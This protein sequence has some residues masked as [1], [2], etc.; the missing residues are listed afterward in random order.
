MK[1]LPFKILILVGDV[2]KDPLSRVPMKHVV[3]ISPFLRNL[4]PGV[5]YFGAYADVH[6]A[7]AEISEAD[8]GGAS[9]NRL[10]IGSGSSGCT[11]IKGGVCPPPFDVVTVSPDLDI[12]PVGSR[13][14]FSIPK[15]LPTGCFG[16]PNTY[17]NFGDGT[18]S[19]GLDNQE[20]DAHAYEYP[21][22][23]RVMAVYQITTSPTEKY[24]CYTEDKYICIVDCMYGD[25][26]PATW[27]YPYIRVIKDA[28]ITGGCGNGNY[29][30]Q[31]LVTREQMA[32][33]L[34]RAVEGDPDAR[35]L[36]RG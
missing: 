2:I 36:Q 15:A 1:R 24:E 14:N 30:P 6:N 3:V 8:N 32:A 19:A 28:G 33:F 7:I 18:T 20:P 11:I 9:Y 31:G 34:V 21:G 29:C 26:S 27:S 12:Y 13:I 23:F 25:I 35:L 17:W 5:Y 10:T 16:E 4:D 22:P